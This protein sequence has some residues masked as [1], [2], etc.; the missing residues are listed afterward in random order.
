MIGRE[1]TNVFDIR[2]ECNIIFREC[3]YKKTADI[4]LDS[5]NKNNNSLLLSKRNHYREQKCDNKTLQTYYLMPF[6]TSLLFFG[7][8]S[9]EVVRLTNSKTN[10][11]THIL[12]ISNGPKIGFL[13]IQK[14]YWLYT[15]CVILSVLNILVT[16]TDVFVC[17]DH[18]IFNIKANVTW[19]F[20]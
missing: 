3:K 8:K 6:F 9:D 5:R 20:F 4:A 14:S 7:Q 17:C 2:A 15:V 12:Q 16:V 10:P 18:M 19:D 11:P 1:D 13:V